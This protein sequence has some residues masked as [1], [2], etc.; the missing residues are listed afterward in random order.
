MSGWG[1]DLTSGIAALQQVGDRFSQLKDELEH[2]IEETIRSERFGVLPGGRRTPAGASTH[3]PNC[4]AVL[5]LQQ[6]LLLLPP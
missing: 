2:S 6:L 3:P 5:R 4:P 1:F